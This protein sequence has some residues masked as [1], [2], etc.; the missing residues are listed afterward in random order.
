MFNFGLEVKTNIY[1]HSRLNTN[2]QNQEM[3]FVFVCWKGWE[4]QMKEAIHA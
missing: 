3:V 4:E 2:E 1:S